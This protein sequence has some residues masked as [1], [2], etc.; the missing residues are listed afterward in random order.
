MTDQL[1]DSS[2][3]WGQNVPVRLAVSPLDVLVTL[4]ASQD[5]AWGAPLPPYWA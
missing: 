2:A 5:W 1:N 3:P 4:H